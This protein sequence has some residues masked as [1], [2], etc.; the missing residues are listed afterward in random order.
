MDAKAQTASKDMI[1][2][3]DGTFLFKKELRPYFDYKLFVDADFEAARKRGAEREAEAFGSMKNAEDMFR[4]RYHAACELYIKEHA[5]KQYADLVI[6]N[7][8]VANPYFG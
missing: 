5:P 6:Q 8:D 1:F 4:S 2:I 7:N 3:M